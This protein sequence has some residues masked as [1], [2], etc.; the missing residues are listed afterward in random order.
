MAD[1]SFTCLRSP[2]LIL[3]RLRAADLPRFCEYRSRPEVA[4][5]QDWDTFTGADGERFLAEQRLLHPDMPGTWFQL[6]IELAASG[7]LAGDCGFHCRLDD[8]RQ[9]EVGITP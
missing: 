6:A 3:R 7:E 8:P 9:A 4:R 1:T 2:R 5:Y